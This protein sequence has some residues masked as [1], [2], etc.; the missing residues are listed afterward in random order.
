MAWFRL[1]DTAP[2][3][4]KVT[5]LARLE[6]LER[7]TAFGRLVGFWCWVLRYAPDGDLSSFD[8][9]DLEEASRLS[10]K[11]LVSV[12]LLD[13]EEDGLRAHDWFE[14][15]GSHKE[16]QRKRAKRL[17]NSKRPKV[18]GNVRDKS[19]TV[20]EMSGN[21]REMSGG[22][23]DRT[24]RQDRPK[25]LSLST[26]KPPTERQKPKFAVNHPRNEEAK[27]VADYY[28]ERNPGKGRA[29]VPGKEDFSHIRERL[30]EGFSVQDLHN[31]IDGNHIEKWHVENRKH[32][33]K[34]VFRN[35][36]KVER[37]IE[38]FERGN[39]VERATGWVGAT[40]ELMEQ[41]ANEDDQARVSVNPGTVAG[42]LPP[43]P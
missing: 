5:K 42:L 30:D 15:A 37:F 25:T 17:S 35:S 32:E 22:Q 41:F 14:R 38:A 6:G 13:E 11:N 33:A 18:S 3:H 34:F 29:L 2:T 21:V 7:D 23:T 24:D 9:D 27:L 39:P 19:G 31:A 16:A 8:A 43:S 28:R 40:Q 36:T 1:E 4:P 10:V 26:D 20:R 12:G